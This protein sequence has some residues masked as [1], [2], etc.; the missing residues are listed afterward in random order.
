M[1]ARLI[2]VNKDMTTHTEMDILSFSFHK[3]AYLPYTK[4]SV[5][6]LTE[7]DNIDDYAE[8]KLYIGGILVQ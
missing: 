2:L 8:V 4:L 7:T 6:F 5:S 1:S 3:D